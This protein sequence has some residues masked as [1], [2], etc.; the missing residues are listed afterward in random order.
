MDKLYKK[1]KG[2][3]FFNRLL[4]WWRESNYPKKTGRVFDIENHRGG[5]GNN[6]SI[7]GGYLSGHLPN[8]DEMIKAGDTVFLET[9][10]GRLGEYIILYVK[11]YYDPP[12]MFKANIAIIDYR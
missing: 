3:G 6:V 5:W 10:S 8:V 11:K 9:Q 7:I 12:D 2:I 4:K 1:V